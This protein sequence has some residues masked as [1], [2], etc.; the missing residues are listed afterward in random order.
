MKI[1][2]DRSFVKGVEIT[3]EKKAK[4]IAAMEYLREDKEAFTGWVNWPTEMPG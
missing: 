3:E 2:L 1:S 4:A